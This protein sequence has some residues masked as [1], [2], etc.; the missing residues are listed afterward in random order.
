M[1][2]IYLFST[3]EQFRTA[4]KKKKEKYWRENRK[5]NLF[6]YYYFELYNILY[7]VEKKY[8]NAML[9]H[10]KTYIYICTRIISQRNKKKLTYT[11]GPLNNILFKNNKK[12]SNWWHKNKNRYI[13][14]FLTK[15]TICNKYKKWRNCNIKVRKFD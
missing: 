5:K 12:N 4:M 10:R 3:H 6:F 9:M 7:G 11:T 2:N 15:L 8:D 14:H 1:G 13:K